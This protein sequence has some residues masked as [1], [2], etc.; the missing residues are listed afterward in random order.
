MNAGLSKPGRCPNTL[1]VAPDLLLEYN[2]VINRNTFLTAGFSV[3]F[4]GEGI[5]NVVA[6]N[7]QKWTGGFIN[8][9]FNY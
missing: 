6:G 5:R 2:H 8:V 3:S 4:P 7:V 1:A 9:V